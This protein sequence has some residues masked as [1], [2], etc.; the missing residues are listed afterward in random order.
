MGKGMKLKKRKRSQVPVTKYDLEL[1]QKKIDRKA[2]EIKDESARNATVVVSAMYFKILI[3]T[4]GFTIDQLNT[5]NR[6]TD[7]LS[8]IISD[9]E[10]PYCWDDLISDLNDKGVEFV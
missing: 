4:F 1:A 9:P 3:D 6:E 5:I 10:N 2:E 7:R 8:E